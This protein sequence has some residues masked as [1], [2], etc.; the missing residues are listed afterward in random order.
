M[1]N[2]T[3]LTLNDNVL[4]HL[5]LAIN[6]KCSDITKAQRQAYWIK[7]SW[8]FTHITTFITL[9]N[10]ESNNCILAVNSSYK[11]CAVTEEHRDTTETSK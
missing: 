2:N 4:F 10:M 11:L 1:S 5:A 3:V 8:H 7:H 9:S 6:I